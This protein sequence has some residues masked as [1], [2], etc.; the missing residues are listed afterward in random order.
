M[1]P[2]PLR[3]LTDVVSRSGDAALALA[4]RERVRLAVTGLSRAGKTV[5]LTSL[6]ANLVAAGQGRRTLPGLAATGGALR[7]ARAIP[8]GVEATPRF[9]AEAHLAA[10]AADP[11]RWP[12]RTEDLS[13]LSLALTL[14]RGGFY[15]QVLPDREVTLDLLDYPGEWLLDL[16]MFGQGFAEWSDETLAR[17]GKGLRAAPAAEFLAFV[18]ALPATA[19]AEDSL[20]RRGHALYRRFLLTAR[21]ELGLRF[22][23]PGRFLNP[24]PG[25]DAP[26]LWFFP[27]PEAARSS[28]LGELMARR[29]EAYLRDQRDRFLDPVFRRFD[30]QVV[31]VDV[32]GALHAGR[33]A[34]E[35]TAEALAAIS[36]TL[37]YGRG[38][39]DLLTGSGIARVAFA[40]TKADHVPEVSRDSLASLL[41][42]LVDAP[43][44]R[45]EIAGAAVT[46]HP[47]ASIRCT[48]EATATHE[49]R[50]SPA[51]RGILL[52]S[53]RWATVDPGLVPARRPPESFWN[54]AYFEMPV[55]RPPG[56]EAGGRG[57]VPHLGLDALLQ[58]L[59]G[60]AL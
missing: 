39:L 47:V 12:A 2:D 32:L 26:V 13:T 22:L 43:R 14:R 38:W 18:R 25:G 57:G 33:E 27:V 21:D 23:Q 7:A 19:P 51:V 17:L 52:E 36:A 1:A 16:P 9:E 46:V 29:H 49:G 41:S 60:D 11:P 50:P 48:G 8:P 28:P 56:L 42:D 10:L 5:F 6:V 58:S 3:L 53:G 4:G 37:R 55:F 54:A 15:G 35:D 24:G 40:A 31:L 45:A 30:R 34:F 20:A 59:L 44:R